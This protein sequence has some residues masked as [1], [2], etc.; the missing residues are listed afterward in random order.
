M[1]PV[2]LSQLIREGSLSDVASDIPVGVTLAEYGA[3]R[4]RRSG[5]RLRLRVA[6]I[7]P[8]RRHR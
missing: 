6:A 5:G 1:P 2:G 7:L 3:A 4:R 8:P